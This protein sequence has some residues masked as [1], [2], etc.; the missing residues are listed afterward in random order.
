MCQ[1]LITLPKTTL[2]V[3]IFQIFLPQLFCESTFSV[4]PCKC[5]NKDIFCLE[6]TQVHTPMPPF[7]RKSRKMQENLEDQSSAS[8]PGGSD[9][10]ASA[11]NVGDLGSIPGL[12]RSPGEENGNPLQCSC[13]ENPMDRGA[14]QATVNGVAKSRIRLSDFSI[15]GLGLPLTYQMTFT[16]HLAFA[17]ILESCFDKMN[18]LVLEVGHLHI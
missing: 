7:N 11:Y 15:S 12:G 1:K 5:F 14:W 2:Y 16:V 13:L 6:T 9:G 10:K 3:L 4:F 18:I 8:L 17:W